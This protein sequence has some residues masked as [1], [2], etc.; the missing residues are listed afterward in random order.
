MKKY[1]II[2]SL[3]LALLLVLDFSYYTLG[4][5]VSFEET[6]PQI[7]AKTEGKNLFVKQNDSFLPFEIRGVN[8]SAS[9]PGKWNSDY[10]VDEETYLRVLREFFA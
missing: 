4:W 1:I 7:L 10:A 9:L 6:E 5:Y 8:L 2:V 3:F